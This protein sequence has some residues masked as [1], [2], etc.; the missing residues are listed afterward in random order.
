MERRSSS[1]ITSLEIPARPLLW[2][3]KPIT[4]KATLGDLL[5]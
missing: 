3:G 5:I 4:G 2:S 1:G